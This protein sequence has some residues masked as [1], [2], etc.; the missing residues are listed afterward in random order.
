M[1]EEAHGT[2]F[3]KQSECILG[4][5]LSGNALGVAGP[6]F[7]RRLD[8][9]RYFAAPGSGLAPNPVKLLGDSPVDVQPWMINAFQFIVAQPT[10]SKVM[11]SERLDGGMD[12]R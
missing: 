9:S 7:G 10:E 2:K 8:V 3:L 1:E 11:N 6:I 4:K 5:C 12:V